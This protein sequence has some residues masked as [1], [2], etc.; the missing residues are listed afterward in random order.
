M[1]CFNST[2]RKTKLTI[3]NTELLTSVH[4]SRFAIMDR[5]IIGSP[6]IILYVLYLCLCNML[7]TYRLQGKYPIELEDS[8]FVISIA[9][10]LCSHAI[11]IYSEIYLQRRHSKVSVT[12][13][14][15]L[16][17]SHN[18]AVGAFSFLVPKGTKDMWCKTLNGS[19]RALQTV[20]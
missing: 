12:W 8:V 7:L 20:F 11:D 18:I 4:Y 6:F 16:C 5:F 13:L 9:F 17:N 14:Y 1:L 10:S 2:N 19:Q 3:Y 15:L